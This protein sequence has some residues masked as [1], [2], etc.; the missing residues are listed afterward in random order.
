MVRKALLQTLAIA[1]LQ[2]GK[3]NKLNCEHSKD[4]WGFLA[5]QQSEGSVDGKFLR[6]GVKGG[7]ESAELTCPHSC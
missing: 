7:W 4:T 1:I 5:K 3:E 6:G 2:E